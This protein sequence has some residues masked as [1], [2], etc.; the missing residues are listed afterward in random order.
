MASEFR[1]PGFKP[2]EIHKEIFS[3]DS[4]IVITPN[5]DKIYEQYAS[6]QSYGTV[7]VKSYSDEDIAKYL[8]TNDYLIIRAHGHVDESSKMIFT[9]GQ[10]G[11][12]RN[13]HAAF[14]KILDALILT[15]TFVFLGCGVNDP[16]IQLVLENANFVYD[17]CMPH[18]FVSPKDSMKEGVREAIE[19]NRNLKFLTYDNI[20]GTHKELLDSIEIL[21][22]KIET[23]REEISDSCTW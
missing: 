19:R 4:R 9:H 12:A 5:V 1:R 3:L 8:R 23:K 15:H 6:S 22:K 13:K 17:Y 7:V 16:D 20:D 2:A 14:Y 21:R 18:Y 10:Y 11:K